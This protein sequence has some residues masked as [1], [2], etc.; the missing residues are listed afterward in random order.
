MSRAEREPIWARP[1][2]A[3]GRAAHTRAD[4]AAAAIRVADAEGLEAVSMR[5]VAKDLGAGT[6]SLYHYV[7]DKDDLVALMTDL[8]LSEY[9]VDEA[10]LDRGWREGL[11]AIA[12]ATRAALR[13]HPWVL[14]SSSLP[15]LGPNTMAHVDQTARAAAQMDVEPA[16]YMEIAGML[17]EYVF[18]CLTRE[19][20]ME[21]TDRDVDA[22]YWRTLLGSGHYPHIARVIAAHEAAGG[23]PDELGRDTDPDG[24]FARG[25]E[26]LLDGVAAELARRR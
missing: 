16:V 3:S 10:Q 24:R 22:D 15:L 6:M 21:R 18:G 13:N 17:D 9:L 19:V 20:A 7:R 14:A 1:E 26:R 25:L 5:R 8:V 11:A 2:P 4:I 12:H 23:A